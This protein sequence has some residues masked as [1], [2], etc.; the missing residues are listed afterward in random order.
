MEHSGRDPCNFMQTPISWTSGKI[1]V[2]YGYDETP[3]PET[4]GDGRLYIVTEGK[5]S[6]QNSF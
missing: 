2:G 4:R 5:M 6:H 3:G 1:P